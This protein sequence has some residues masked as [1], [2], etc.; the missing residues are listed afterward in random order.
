MYMQYITTGN[1]CYYGCC[2]H[3][4]LTR[5]GQQDMKP[6]NTT[7]ATLVNMAITGPKK[8]GE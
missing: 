4:E 3:S 7:D 6:S 2:R 5:D 1:S 8:R